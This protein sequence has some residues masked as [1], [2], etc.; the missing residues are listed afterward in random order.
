LADELL[1]GWAP[2]IETIELIPSS[3]G[4]FEVSLDGDL[5]FSKKALGRH[6]APREIVDLVRQRIGPEIP[7]S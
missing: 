7:R 5:I 4:R 3:N 6:A 1:S 2:I